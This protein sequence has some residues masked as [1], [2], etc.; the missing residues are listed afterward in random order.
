M[1]VPCF[2]NDI[3]K[4]P[5]V[6]SQRDDDPVVIRGSGGFHFGTTSINVPWP[7][8]TVAG[9]FAVILWTNDFGG[10]VP[11]GWTS[12]YQ[13]ATGNTSGIDYGCYYKVLNSADITAGSVTL[14]FS[15]G[16]GQGCALITTFQDGANLQVSMAGHRKIGTATTTIPFG[17]PTF[18]VVM[19]L[20]AQWSTGAISFSSLTTYDSHI[21]GTRSARCSVYQPGSNA[22]TTETFTYTSP[23]DCMAMIVNISKGGGGNHRAAFAN[24]IGAIAQDTRWMVNP[25]YFEMEITSLLGVVGVGVAS[26]QQSFTAATLGLGTTNVI[27][28]SNGQVRFNNTTLTTIAPFSQGDIVC[29]AY[30]ATLAQIWFRV[31][32]GSW[33]NN[34]S[35]NP[36]TLVGG[37]DVSAFTGG[38]AAPAASFSVPGGAIL[39]N[40]NTSDFVYTPPTGYISVGEYDVTIADNPIALLAPVVTEATQDGNP[41]MGMVPEGYHIPAAIFPAG[42]VQ[43]IAGE[44]RENDVGVPDRIVRIYNRTTG[45]LIGT[46]RTN[47]VGEFSIPA[48]DSDAQHYVIALDDE[49]DPEYNAKIYDRVLPG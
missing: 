41:F 23:A 5:D 8:G 3:L 38:Q 18:N 26:R 25:L 16:S 24:N 6:V 11:S 1:T 29:V 14:T 36:V 34:G 19:A 4:S 45:D 7:A 42:P 46:T 49:V 27:Y 13:T 40:F 20:A 22:G 9:D 2:F 31:N 47:S 10:P 12:L 15:N 48:K 32:N 33:N 39:G 35:A 30:N 17:A 21:T 43:L 44:V 37:I 28:N